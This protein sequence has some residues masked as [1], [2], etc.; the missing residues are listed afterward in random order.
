M[1]APTLVYALL[2]IPFG[3]LL[4]IF[5]AI[6]LTVGY[7]KD[8][9]RSLVSLAASAVAL[10]VSL[11]LAKL[12]GWLLSGG[13]ASLLSG[14]LPAEEGMGGSLVQSVAQSAAQAVLSFVLFGLFFIIALIVLKS[15]GKKISW[16]KL[17]KLN[18]G[19][20]KTKVA[21]MGVRLVD[22]LLVVLMLLLPLYGTLAFAVPPVSAVM[23][24]SVTRF[25]K[26]D[27]PALSDGI[28]DEADGLSYDAEELL[29]DYATSDRE[30][31]PSAD[32]DAEMREL[33]KAV[34]GHPVLAL[35]KYGPADWV[36]SSLS[37]VSMNGQ[38]IDIARAAKVLEGLLDRLMAFVEAQ[39][40]PDGQKILG[41]CEELVS[42]TRRNV[43]E[44]RWFYNIV[45]AVLG[46]MDKAVAQLPDD[47][48]ETGFESG[49]ETYKQ[50]R[51]LADMS[52]ADFK[53]N[54][55]AVLGFAEYIL[56]SDLLQTLQEDPE[57]LFSQEMTKTM[58]EVG[59]RVGGLINHSK[60][61]VVLKKLVLQQSAYSQLRYKYTYKDADGF[62]YDY[63]E[64]SAFEASKAFVDTY[65]DDEPAAE[66]LWQK[67][68]LA[69]LLLVVDGGTDLDAVE[70][71][72]RYPQFGG[73]AA[74]ELLYAERITAAAGGEMLC[75]C[76]LGEEDDVADA[77]RQSLEKDT[78]MLET[79]KAKLKTYESASWGTPAFGAFAEETAAKQLGVG[80]QITARRAYLEALRDGGD[81]QKAASDVKK[82][83]AAAIKN[84]QPCN[85]YDRYGNISG[86]F[87][88]AYRED[89][90]VAICVELYNDATDEAW[91]YIDGKEV[92]GQVWD[93][94]GLRH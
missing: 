78:R 77:V 12:L 89:G 42:Y 51:S 49:L 28:A 34:E 86:S 7:K 55:V 25:M 47:G 9:G 40:D 76:Y 71:F 38:T 63:D 65:C 94:Q 13:A 41:A 84:E 90:K 20:A 23:D 70:L 64:R 73:E 59:T 37:S 5:A 88:L 68:G 10:V 17:D 26:G 52:Y 56:K 35:Y 15:V 18:T 27:T 62:V 81:M 75:G 46:E 85:Y 3:L 80:D 44:E 1:T 87:R 22:A 79:M 50:I 14:L 30:E 33:V 58:E 60:Q 31:T 48:E 91:Y 32:S 72:A 39:E 4:V 61:A 45:M 67:E 19:T 93:K 2:F 66:E 57:S 83:Y 24:L 82:A 8:L 36:Y 74:A 69:F 92:T 6:F 21:G 11:L 29:E 43:V 16:D 53:S 54:G